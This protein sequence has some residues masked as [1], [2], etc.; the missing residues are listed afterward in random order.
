MSDRTRPGYGLPMLR[1]LTLLGSRSLLGG[2][3]AAHGAQKLFGVLGGHGLEGTGGFFE[4]LGLRPGK[5]MA[6]VAGASELGGGVL[7]VLGHL[8]PI[9][10]VAVASTLGVAASTAHRGNGP[11]AADGGP[12]LALVQL[13]GALAVAAS[14]PGRLAVGKRLP[15][16]AGAA[17]AAIGVGA[18]IALAQRARAAQAAAAAA[19]PLETELPFDEAPAAPKHV[20]AA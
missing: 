13:A 15:G 1:D 14:G 17:V 10:P 4:T 3:A 5:P 8:H 2:Y 12:E 16:W 18:G 11:M 7:T 9:G 20:R 19:E 6:A